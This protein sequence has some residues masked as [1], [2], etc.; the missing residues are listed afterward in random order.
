M[1]V[2][3]AINLQRINGHP[4]TRHNHDTGPRFTHAHAL[5]C[6][7]ATVV[8]GASVVFVGPVVVEMVAVA[9]SDV[10]QPKNSVYMLTDT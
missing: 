9:A 10:R 6:C 3:L 4:G 2:R 1:V 8:V 5:S 7:C